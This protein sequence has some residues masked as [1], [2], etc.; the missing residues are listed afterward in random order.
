MFGRTVCDENG[1]EIGRL[2]RFE[3]GGFHVTTAEGVSMLAQAESEAGK[4]TLPWWCAECG[5]SGGST[6]CRSRVP[7]AAAPPRNC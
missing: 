5:E 4:K 6:T 1:D 2:R 3:D 7:P